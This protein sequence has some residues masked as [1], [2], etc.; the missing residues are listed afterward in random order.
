MVLTITRL[1]NQV[2]TIINQLFKFFTYMFYLIV[3]DEFV[4]LQISG[5]NIYHKLVFVL[6]WTKKAKTMYT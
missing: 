1:N 4:L 2:I 3:S 6:I 5:K